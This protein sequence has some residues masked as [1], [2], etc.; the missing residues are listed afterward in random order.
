MAYFRQVYVVSEA[1]QPLVS[2]RGRIF[3]ASDIN[4]EHPLPVTGGDGIPITFVEISDVGV[5]QVFEVEDHTQVRWISED[6]QVHAFFESLEGME[7]RAASAE[8]TASTAVQQVA[9]FQGNVGVP[10]GIAALNS[11]GNVVDAN[12]DVVGNDTRRTGA[13]IHA[14]GSQSARPTASPDV[15]VLWI[16]EGDPPINARPGVDY[17]LNGGVIQ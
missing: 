4:G 6:G 16:T 12:D 9:D 7:E 17:W 11:E 8:A 10:G 3:A 14:F 2:A 13:V 1:G 5:N 15:M